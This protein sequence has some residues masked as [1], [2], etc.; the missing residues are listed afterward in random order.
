MGFFFSF[1]S[2]CRN[3]WSFAELDGVDIRTRGNRLPQKCVARGGALAHA[4]SQSLLQ[5]SGPG[6]L[7]S[8]VRSGKHVGKQQSPR[9]P[10]TSRI[11]SVFSH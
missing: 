10:T 5:P 4:Q 3:L 9:V 2:H 11:V 8:L 7:F 6:S 1:T